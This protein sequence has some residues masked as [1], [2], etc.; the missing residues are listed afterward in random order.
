[1]GRLRR[2]PRGRVVGL[3]CTAMTAALTVAALMVGSPAQATVASDT[4]DGVGGG[5]V[6]DGPGGEF[7]CGP[8]GDPLEITF[9]VSGVNPHVLDVSLSI[10]VAH[11]WMGDLDVRLIAPDGTSHVI[12]SRVGATTTGPGTTEAECGDSSPL[13]GNYFFTDLPSGSSF[14]AAAAATPGDLQIPAGDYRTTTPGGAPG[15][16][17]D[18]LMT[19]AF[20]GAELNG[21][22]TLRVVDVGVSEVGE[23]QAARLFLVTADDEPSLAF[24]KAAGGIV[25][26]DGNG[27]DPGDT[28]TYGFTVTNTGFFPLT[29]VAVT[30]PMLDGAVSCGGGPLDPGTSRVCDAVTY[31][32]TE[33]DLDTTIVNTATASAVGPSGDVVEV[34]ATATTPIPPA[35]ATPPT[36]DEPV[37]STDEP[38][39]TDEPVPP[40]ATEVSVDTTEPPTAT[41]EAP[42][43]TIEEPSVTVGETVSTSDE[44]VTTDG[45]TPITESSAPATEAAVPTTEGAQPLGFAGSATWRPRRAGLLRPGQ[46]DPCAVPPTTT[47]PPVAPPPSVGVAPVGEGGGGN[48]GGGA[49]G[50]GRRATGAPPVSGTL[51]VTGSSPTTMLAAAAAIITGLA[52]ASATRRRHNG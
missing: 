24:A 27:V 13:F 37:P 2:R 30:D 38:S 5:A 12:F 29:D 21:I 32:L 35:C 34:T 31:E 28:L 40:A 11:T 14:A 23:I 25:D 20:A 33:D 6:P 50:D 22:W 43:A 9:D 42:T 18:S 17:Q 47:P 39:T 52:L 16:S 45:T 48:G 1:M 49:T 7:G 3:S 8:P 51:P 36:T 19:P 10:D 46:V 41:T 26:G 4:F 15:G 44:P